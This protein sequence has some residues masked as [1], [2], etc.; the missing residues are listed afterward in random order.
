MKIP[1]LGHRD[2]SHAVACRSSAMITADEFLSDVRTL[3]N[4]LPSH[5]FTVNLCRDRY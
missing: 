1:F 5:Q 4:R 3:A 2:G